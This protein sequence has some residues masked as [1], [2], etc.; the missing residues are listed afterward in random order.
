LRPRSETRNLLQAEST[1][2]RVQ[3]QCQRGRKD[4]RGRAADRSRAICR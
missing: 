2:H 1:R 3:R 4:D